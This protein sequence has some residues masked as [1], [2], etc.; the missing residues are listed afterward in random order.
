MT[1]KQLKNQYARLCHE[2]DSMVHADRAHADRLTRLHRE[3]DRIDQDLATIRERAQ[4]APL[5]SEVV[6][7]DRPPRTDLSPQG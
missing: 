6:L 3:L 7:I 2:I 5:L 1:L 4:S